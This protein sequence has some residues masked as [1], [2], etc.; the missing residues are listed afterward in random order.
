[1]SDVFKGQSSLRIRLDTKVDI[2]G[3]KEVKIKYIKPDDVS[4]GTW[5]AT[6]ENPLKGIIYYDIPKTVTNPIIDQ[7]GWW[8]F[9]AYIK[10]SD[11]RVAPG[12]VVR[13]YFT[14]EGD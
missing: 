11:D 7:S 4:T 6:V 9:W 12:E 1:M 5:T 8:R 14:I 13:Q 3:A 10:F 2:T